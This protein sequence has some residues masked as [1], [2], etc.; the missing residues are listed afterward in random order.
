[1]T[2]R[3]V[4]HCSLLL[5]CH[6]AAPPRSN[7]AAAALQ[8]SC[9]GW[10]AILGSMRQHVLLVKCQILQVKIA[11]VQLLRALTTLPNESP[12]LQ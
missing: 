11:A 5:P 3:T 8:S 4:Q 2:D 12:S 6:H 9:L 1:M 10:A 7:D